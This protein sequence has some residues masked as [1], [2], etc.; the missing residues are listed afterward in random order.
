[1]AV[2]YWTGASSGEWADDDNWSGNQPGASDTAVFNGT[3]STQKVTAA[4]AV[5]GPDVI[6]VGQDYTY[7][8]GTSGNPITFATNA[9]TSLHIFGTGNHYVDGSVTVGTCLVRTPNKGANAVKLDGAV[10]NLHLIQGR[11][12]LQSTLTVTTLNIGYLSSGASDVIGVI[13]SGVTLTTANMAGGTVSC[14]SAAT[15]VT[16]EGGYWKH[17][18]GNVA[19]CNIHAGGTFDYQVN[20][21]TI[22]ALNIFGGRADL[23]QTGTAKTVTACSIWGNGVLDLRSGTAS[24]TVTLTG[25]PKAFG[26]GAQVLQSG[27]SFA[28]DR[29]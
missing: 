20:G 5:T 10:T 6:I 24:G 16:I 15:T 23:S 17:T 28:V 21:G 1:M 13:E 11:C 19:T 22:T 4:A 3:Q 18:T 25:A 8:F 29:F 14:D 2:T 9:P 27:S 12:T 26:D 7:D